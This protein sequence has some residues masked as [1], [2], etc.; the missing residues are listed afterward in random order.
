MKK[1][2]NV[3]ELMML[4]SEY[5]ADTKVLLNGAGGGYEP[6]HEDYIGEVGYYD[7]NSLSIDTYEPD[8][9]GETTGVLISRH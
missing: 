1:E 6:V 9:A 7:A 4:L 5:P 3:G 2:L 8:L